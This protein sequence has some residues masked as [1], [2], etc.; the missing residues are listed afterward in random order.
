MGCSGCGCAIQK[1]PVRGPLPPNRIFLVHVVGL[2]LLR[3]RLT[4]D[5]PVKTRHLCLARDDSG[6]GVLMLSRKKSASRCYFWTAPERRGSSHGHHVWD[7]PTG[8]AVG[9]PP[10]GSMYATAVA[11]AEKRRPTHFTTQFPSDSTDKWP[12]KS[13][14]TG[15]TADLL[16]A[17]H[18]LA[19]PHSAS[20]MR[21]EEFRC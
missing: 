9:F 1:G 13:S 6:K 2:V 11:L 21:G 12:Q 4:G 16:D 19:R 7:S 10:T 15:A 5:P 18:D 14:T 20:A 17:L 8:L 3:S